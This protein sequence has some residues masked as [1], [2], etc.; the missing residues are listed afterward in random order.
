MAEKKDIRLVITDIDNTIAD[1]FGVWAHALDAAMERLS[2]LYGRPRE[3]IARDLLEHIP[4]SV[5]HIPGPYIGKDLRGDVLRTPSLQPQ[6][7]E[8]A[9]GLEKILHAWDKD[10]SRAELYDGVMPAMN[11]IR[12]SGARLVLYSDSRESVCIPRLAKMGITADMVDGVYVQPDLREGR[13]VRMPVAGPAK[14]LRDGLGGRLVVLDPKTA[15]PN[16]ANMKRIIAEMGIENPAEA[17]MVGDNIRADGTGA[18]AAGINFAW[19]RAGTE[20]DE[21]TRRCYEEF[22]RDPNYK[23]TTQ[24]HLEQMNASNR[25][26]EI[27]ENGFK[28]IVK[29]YRF[30]SAE[31]TRADEVRTKRAEKTPKPAFLSRLSSL[32]RGR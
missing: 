28:D 31:R 1:K 11:K 23:I 24:D 10:R 29:H 6:G 18:I 4:E 27:L 25:P 30:V 19:Q 21:V 13:P 20:I 8:Q 2:G 22:C 12:A 15:K 5:R 26:T 3:D 9:V 7:H 17:V 32:V 16:A 14:A